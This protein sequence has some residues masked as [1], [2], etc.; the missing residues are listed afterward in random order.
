[1]GVGGTQEGALDNARGCKRMKGDLFSW[2]NAGFIASEPHS[3][4]PS[5]IRRL[6]I[7]CKFSEGDVIRPHVKCLHDVI[8]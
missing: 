2:E 8:F 7:N 4:I 5:Q 6:V 1:M 3:S